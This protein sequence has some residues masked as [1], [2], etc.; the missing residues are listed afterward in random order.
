M[1]AS[2]ANNLKRDGWQAGASWGYEVVLPPKFNFMLADNSIRKPVREWEALGIR[3]AG[4]KAFPRAGDAASLFTPAGA[5]G[6]AFLLVEN[7][8]VIMK[9]NPAESYAL[10][11]GHL[12]D[13]MRG[14]APFVQPWPRDDGTLS[15]NDRYELQ[16]R[17]AS[18]GYDIGEADGNLG[19]RT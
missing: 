16:T 18:L 13:R 11:V 4:G 14:G 15:R 9:Y 5:R 8:R 12:A 1:L 7:F 17:L 10:A 3:R 2:T 19:P 6:P